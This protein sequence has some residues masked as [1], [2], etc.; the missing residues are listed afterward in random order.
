M[1]SSDQVNVHDSVIGETRHCTWSHVASYTVEYYHIL[2]HSYP[3]IFSQDRRR[4]EQTLTCL[5]CTRGGGGGYGGGGV[6][7][8]GG[9]CRKVGGGADQKSSCI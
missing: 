4:N 9:V 1:I 5:H 7:G 2:K 6:W 8:G 3:V